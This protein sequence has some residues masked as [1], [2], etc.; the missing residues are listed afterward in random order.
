MAARRYR[1]RFVYW[2]SYPFPEDYLYRAKEPDARYPLLY[3]IRGSVFKFLLYRVLLPAADHIIVQS[4]QMKLNVAAEGVPLHKMTAV[5]MGIKTEQLLKASATGKR[6]LIPEGVRCFLYLGTFRSV[7]KIDFLV[8]VLAQ[9]RAVLPDVQ[10]Y[11]VG[12]GDD[13]SDE[14]TLLAEAARLGVSDALVLTGQLPQAEALRYVAEADVCVS[15]L[16]PT[17]VLDVGSPTKLVEYMAM[18]KAVVANDHPEQRLVLEESGAGYCVPYVEADFA[19]A[20]IKLLKNPEVARGMGV[21]GRSYAIQNRSY[22]GLADIVEEMFLTLKEGVGLSGRNCMSEL[23]RLCIASP[24]QHGGGA[25]YQISCL[26]DTLAATGRFDIS[27]LARHVESGVSAHKY[28]VV[29]IGRNGNVPR[30]GYMVDAHLSIT[31][32]ARY[33]HTSSI[34]ESLVVILASVPFTTLAGRGA[35]F[36]WHVAH[37]SDVTMDSAVYGRNPLRRFLEKRSVEY[38]IRHAS[39]I[40]TQ[41][42]DQARLL[43]DNYGRQAAAVIPN[44]HPHPEEPL[45]KEASP[46]VVWVANL[47]PWKRPDVFVRLANRLGDIAGARFIMVGADQGGAGN[48]RWH[49]EL[50]KSISKPGIWSMSVS[51]RKPRSMSCLPVRMCSS[52]PV[53][54][55]AFPIPLSRPGCGQ[56]LWSA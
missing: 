10:L 9:V 8:R 48:Q 7:R 16:Y 36:V 33:G 38:G 27:Y 18:E 5:P 20:V 12:S 21:R 56:F 40:V 53:P 2:L 13:P 4:E 34:S 47:K 14:Q 24:F 41:T 46:L 54:R 30:L 3:F 43:A 52:T 6:Q 44:F 55:R 49:D 1:K 26:I 23:I 11:L 35:R 42:H 25:E 22:T 17:P 28:S 39:H 15:P 29:K 51:Y 32:C 37:E 31:L 19:D 50:M 45:V